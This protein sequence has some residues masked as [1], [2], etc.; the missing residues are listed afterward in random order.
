MGKET[1]VQIAS[2]EDLPAAVDTIVTMFKSVGLPYFEKYSNLLNID[3]AL[4]AAPDT[5]CEHRIM[6]YL[7]AAT[8]VIVARLVG[9][10]DY[11]ELIVAYHNQMKRF[12]GG[13]YLS[14]YEKLLKVL[15]D[16][17]FGKDR[18]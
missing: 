8:G 2:P 13:F 7:R 15:A 14:Q 10:K 6:N 4:N 16:V 3:N 11:E 1:Y 9:R 5:P 17:P 18:E 12:A